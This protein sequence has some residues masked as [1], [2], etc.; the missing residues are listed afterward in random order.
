[1]PRC[2]QCQRQFKNDLGLKIHIGKQHGAKPKPRAGPGRK[3]AARGGLTCEVCG[4]WFKLPL[5]L[6]RHRSVAHGKARRPKAVRRAS[7]APAAPAGVDV[8]GVT[9]EQLLV[10]KAAVDG[11]LADIAAKMRKAKVGT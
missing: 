1:M 2:P 9:I 11:R 7:R 10:L 6:G 3:K 5:H 4:R 8:S